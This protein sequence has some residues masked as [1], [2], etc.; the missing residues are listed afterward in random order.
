ME[1]LNRDPVPLLHF[2]L[3]TSDTALADVLIRRFARSRTLSLRA[4]RDLA[5]LGGGSTA[6]S[7]ARRTFDALVVLLR[8]DGG[9]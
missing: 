3:A 8:L 5:G 2:A 6:V 9:D 7:V 4:L 1:H